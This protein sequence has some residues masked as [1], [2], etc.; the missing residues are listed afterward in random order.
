ME[1]RQLL[2]SLEIIDGRELPLAEKTCNSGEILELPVD[3]VVAHDNW[4]GRHVGDWEDRGRRGCDLYGLLGLL[5]D[6]VRIVL[7]YLQ[8]NAVTR[9]LKGKLVNAM[10]S[11]RSL[12][13]I[14]KRVTNKF[15]TVTMN[16]ERSGYDLIRL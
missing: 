10:T 6:W 4:A 11:D 5:I 9:L 1:V 3:L 7:R 15:S 8:S 14:I 16:I 13:V 2:M 12:W